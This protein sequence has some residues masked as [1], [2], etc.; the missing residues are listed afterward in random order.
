MKS[1]IALVTDSI[2]EMHDTVKERYQSKV[3][4]CSSL[5][6]LRIQ[7]MAH[8]TNSIFSNLM[9][10]KVEGAMQANITSPDSLYKRN[11]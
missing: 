8:N 1:R 7:T 9:Y 6:L 11:T 2:R 5:G 4:S 10:Q 3:L